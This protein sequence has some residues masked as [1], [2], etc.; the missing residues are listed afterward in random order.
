M[1]VLETLAS[2]LEHP[3][4]QSKEDQKGGHPSPAMLRSVGNSLRPVVLPGR[5]VHPQKPVSWRAGSAGRKAGLDLQRQKQ[6]ILCPDRG[7]TDDWHVSESLGPRVTSHLAGQGAAQRQ[8]RELPDVFAFQ[9]RRPFLLCSCLPVLGLSFD[10]GCSA[11]R[12]LF[13][14]KWTHYA[15]RCWKSESSLGP[16]ENFLWEI[17]NFVLNSRCHCCSR[18][19][20][21]ALASTGIFLPKGEKAQCETQTWQKKLQKMN[22]EPHKML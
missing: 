13:P 2:L 1:W 22:V 8:A 6:S 21:R 3:L 4:F 11:W 16:R 9:C 10:V 19:S 7:P 14:A 17:T 20:A 18:E 5:K 15:S 12:Y